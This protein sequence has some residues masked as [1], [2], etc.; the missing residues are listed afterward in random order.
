MP[1]PSLCSLVS[2]GVTGSYIDALSD[3]F[4]MVETVH[5]CSQHGIRV[6]SVLESVICSLLRLPSLLSLSL[7]SL[8]TAKRASC[9]KEN[10]YINWC[11]TP[12]IAL[13]VDP[14]ISWH[15]VIHVMYQY[16][17]LYFSNLSFSNSTRLFLGSRAL[18]ALF[19]LR[20]I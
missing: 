11:G 12:V 18:L 19:A 8:F 5:P 2:R 15:P 14:Y 1:L 6:I 13:A 10:D 20:H 17:Y 9:R 4:D 7:I 3:T 16:L